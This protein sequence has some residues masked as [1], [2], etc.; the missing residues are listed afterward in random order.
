MGNF[1]LSVAGMQV[2]PQTLSLWLRVGSKLLKDCEELQL[3]LLS[4]APLIDVELDLEDL[5][6]L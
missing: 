2:D 4:G 6:G 5:R 3:V 1:L